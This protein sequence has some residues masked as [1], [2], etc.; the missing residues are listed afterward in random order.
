MSLTE[1]VFEPVASFFRMNRALSISLLTNLVMAS[2]LTFLWTH[3][4]SQSPSVVSIVKNDDEALKELGKKLEDLRKE[5]SKTFEEY[6]QQMKVVLDSYSTRIADLEKK[7]QQ[8][9]KT[10]VDSH[11]GDMAGLASDF[12]KTTGIQVR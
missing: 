8:E 5:H 3:R 11:R 2:V 12:S 7:K 4:E 1:K 10:I 9:T 6:S